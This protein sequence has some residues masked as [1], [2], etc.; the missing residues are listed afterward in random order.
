GIKGDVIFHGQTPSE[1]EI[2]E[3]FERTEQKRKKDDLWRKEA[4]KKTRELEDKRK[5][6]LKEKE[7]QKEAASFDMDATGIDSTDPESLEKMSLLTSIKMYHEFW[8]ELSDTCPRKGKWSMKT[9]KKDL[10]DEIVR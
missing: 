5:E 6:F 1:K 10:Q 3:A 8:P 7:R 2:E 9:S 4:D